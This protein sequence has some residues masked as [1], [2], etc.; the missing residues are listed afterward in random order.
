MEKNYD[1]T[2]VFFNPKL[3]HPFTAKSGV[4]YVNISVPPKEEG[5]LWGQFLVAAK[6]KAGADRIKEAKDGRHYVTFGNDFHVTVS[7]YDKETKTQTEETL[8]PQ[9]LADRYHTTKSKNDE[10]Q[11]EAETEMER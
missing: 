9:E 8:T 4:D 7:Y 1:V 11:Q 3:E 2:N 5:G 10:K 6:T